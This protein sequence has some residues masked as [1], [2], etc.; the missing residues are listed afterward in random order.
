MRFGLGSRREGSTQGRTLHVSR[1]HSTAE[2]ARVRAPPCPSLIPNDLWELWLRGTG[3]DRCD[4][5]WML[6]S[7]IRQIIELSSQT[8]YHHLSVSTLFARRPEAV[9]GLP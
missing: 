7:S 6:S 9:S 1:A 2:V 5:D 3:T 8:N 4:P